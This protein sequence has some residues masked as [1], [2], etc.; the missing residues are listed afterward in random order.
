MLK[1]YSIAKKLFAT[2]LLSI[3]TL[4]FLQLVFIIKYDAFVHDMANEE[5]QLIALLFHIK[6]AQTE[7]KIEVQEWKNILIRGEDS[8]SYD[9]YLTGLKKQ[10]DKVDAHLTEAEKIVSETEKANSIKVKIGE[11]RAAWKK[12]NEA[13]FTALEAHPFGTNGENYKKLDRAVKGIDR[14]PNETLDDAAKLSE[15]FLDTTISEREADAE[16]FRAL[17]FIIL[18]ISIVVVCIFGIFVAKNITGRL[19]ILSNNLNAFFDYLDKK[20][21]Q[22][23]FEALDGKDEFAQMQ[24][25]FLLLS[26]NTVS[27]EEHKSQFL[28]DLQQFIDKI[29]EGNLEARLQCSLKDKDSQGICEKINDMAHMLNHSVARDLNTL[30][31][32]L[33]NFSKQDFT[34]NVPDA[35]AK[36][37]VS[38]NTLGDEMRKLLQRSSQ[39]SSD[40][41]DTSE[42]LNLLVEDLNKRVSSEAKEIEESSNLIESVSYS[43][44]TLNGQV[45]NV[46]VQTNNIR[47]IVGVINDIAEQTNLLALNAAIE[48]A[49]A[50]EH[51]RGF[52]VVADEVRKLAE[53]TQ[54]SLSEINANINMLVQSVG[55][56]GDSMSKQNIAVSR[57]SS[58]I[59]EI[60]VSA[61]ASDQIAN[62]TKR[63]SD[64][65]L[66]ISVAIREELSTKRF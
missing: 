62:E 22:P 31:V 30:I 44:V 1:H 41:R 36:I 42:K 63:L 54:K 13:Y 32:V 15:Q 10:I 9:K 14:A 5:K 40:L 52:A 2:L 3:F 24:A 50:G 23:K 61:E 16:S 18:A 11:F 35:Y 26:A 45:E 65:V 66:N 21:F 55:D 53:R 51:G 25:S 17:N 43:I 59:S 8:K 33:E 39:N 6:S 56:I 64:S 27:I 57:A 4:G 28:M 47:G 12:N 7:F 37:A 49:R 38:A 20:T 19:H 29:K 60:K 48:A 46:V 58:A 34:H